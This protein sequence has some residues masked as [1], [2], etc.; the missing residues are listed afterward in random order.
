MSKNK[1]KTE[2][3]QSNIRL[4]RFQKQKKNKK[5]QKGQHSNIRLGRVQ[6]SKVKLSIYLWFTEYV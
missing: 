1:Q 3:E 6:I 4:G 2:G 5:K